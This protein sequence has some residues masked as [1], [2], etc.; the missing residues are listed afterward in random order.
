[1]DPSVHEAVELPAKTWLRLH[2]L[3]DSLHG[4]VQAREVRVKLAVDYRWKNDLTFTRGMCSDAATERFSV[5]LALPPPTIRSPSTAQP[6]SPRGHFNCLGETNTSGEF[7]NRG[8]VHNSP[9]CSKTGPTSVS[10]PA[11]RCCRLGTDP[12][13]G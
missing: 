8:G 10:W 3:S 13:S 1:M 5:N 4:S 12:G 9:K 11:G 7:R 2:S 6:I